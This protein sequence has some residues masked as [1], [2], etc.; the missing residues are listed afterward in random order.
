M[1]PSGEN[2]GIKDAF[3]RYIVDGDRGAIGFDAG[4]KAAGVYVLDV[5]AGGTATIR[6]RLTADGEPGHRRLLLALPTRE[7]LTRVLSRLLDESEFLSPF[8]VRSLSK[9][10]KSEPYTFEADGRAFTVGYV[11]GDMDTADF[12]GNSNWRGPV[13]MPINFLLVEALRTYHAF[14]G[15]DLRVE[16][17]TG[18]GNRVTLDEAAREIGRRLAALF[19]RVDGR[20]RPCHGTF[21]RFAD[22]PHW[23]DHVLFHEYFHG[24]T[25]RGLGAGHQTGWTALVATLIEHCHEYK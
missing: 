8:G 9:V 12:G 23:K 13:W 7:R 4:T 20:P 1:H 24:D 3:H 25:G 15:D 2:K 22:A 11:P 5:P 18:S 19:L 17:P 6:L 16:C 14:Y 10:Y 21:E